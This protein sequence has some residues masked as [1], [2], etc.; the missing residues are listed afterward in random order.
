MA[1][2]QKIGGG[3]KPAQTVVKEKTSIEMLHDCARRDEEHVWFSVDRVRELIGR[4]ENHE[5][6]SPIATML[7]RIG[8][9]RGGCL[10]WPIAQIRYLANLCGEQTN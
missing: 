1:K 6:H 7:D 8:G 10:W 3:K 4:V 5:S 9:Q 2:S